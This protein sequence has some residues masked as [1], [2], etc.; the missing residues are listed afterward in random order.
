MLN[1]FDPSQA[2]TLAV[3]AT[4]TATDQTGPTFKDTRPPDTVK[5][6]GES[7]NMCRSVSTCP[8]NWPL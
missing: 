1:G 6:A 3:Q 4:L 7:F 8:K 2:V 5:L